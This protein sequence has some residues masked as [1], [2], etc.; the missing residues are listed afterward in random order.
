MPSEINLD[1]FSFGNTGNESN[2][3][4]NNYGFGSSDSWFTDSSSSARDAANYGNAASQEPSMF[5]S[6]WKWSNTNTG[7]S[8]L[9]GALD[10]GMKAWAVG[11]ASDASDEQNQ[12]YAEQ[13]ALDRE[14]AMALAML[15]ENRINRHNESINKPWDLGLPVLKK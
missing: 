14:A 5:D 9:G 1:G 11:K 8:M 12:F 10:A 3:S 13:K 4:T 7:S 2:F 6:I 15:K